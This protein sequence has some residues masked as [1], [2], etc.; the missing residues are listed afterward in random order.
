MGLFQFVIPVFGTNR[1]FPGEIL[2]QYPISLSS[3]SEEFQSF[4]SSFIFLW[5]STLRNNFIL[6][7]LNLRVGKLKS[8][9][10][11]KSSSLTNHTLP[12]PYFYKIFVIKTKL[13]WKWMFYKAV[14]YN[15]FLALYSLQNIRAGVTLI[16]ES[17]PFHRKVEVADQPKWLYIDM[18]W[19][20]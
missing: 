14:S 11:P 17:I 8:R 20:N 16:S 9:L 12:N 13:N 7:P 1:L 3:N 4:L 15:Y 6:Y 10:F 2:R 19:E 18:K 5:A